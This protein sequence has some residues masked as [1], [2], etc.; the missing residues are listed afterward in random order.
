MKAHSI[1]CVSLLFLLVGCDNPQRKA[2]EVAEAQRKAAAPAYAKFREA[3]AAM[4]VC[5]RGSTYA[6]FRK[7]RLAIETCYEVNKPFLTG[8]ADE[9]QEL[10]ALMQACDTVFPSAVRYSEIPVSPGD[11]EL[12]KAMV[13]LN[14][15]LA[16]KTN[17]SYAEMQKDHDFFKDIA[18]RRALTM[19]DERCDN[20]IQKLQP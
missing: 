8:V 11:R 5:T 10:S 17:L 16:A 1:L 12:W 9:F 15:P 13:T 2:A 14:P 3:L 6:E 19:I 7:Q 4:K 20:L 18:V